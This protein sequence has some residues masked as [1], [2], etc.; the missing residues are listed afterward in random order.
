M[1]KEEFMISKTF[2]DIMED[3]SQN[4][5]FIKQNIRRLNKNIDT[6][7]EKDQINFFNETYY[8]INMEFTF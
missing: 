5:T 7:N 2:D 6:F 4:K 8:G 1:V 3:I